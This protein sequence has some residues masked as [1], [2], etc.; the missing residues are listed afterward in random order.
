LIFS[1]H[2]LVGSHFHADVQRFY[3]FRVGH[4]EGE[5]KVLAAGTRGEE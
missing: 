2:Q 5:G 3:C 1:F 4:Y